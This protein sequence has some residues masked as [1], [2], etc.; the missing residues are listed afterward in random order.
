MMIIEAKNISY[1]YKNVLPYVIALKRINLYVNEGEM[2]AIQGPSGS[3][4]STLLHILGCM[5]PCQC[6]ELYIEGL[7]VSKLTNEQLSFLRNQK[8]GFIFQNPYLLP[9]SNILENILLPTNYPCEMRSHSSEYQKIAIDYAEKLGI[10]HRLNHFPNKLSGG[11]R[12]RVAIARGLIRGAKI[13]LADEPTGDLDSKRSQQ[14]IEYLKEMQRSE[15]LTVV[16]ITHNPEV[17]E[18][19]DRIVSIADGELTQT[20][21]PKRPW[22]KHKGSK[23]NKE[24]TRTEEFFASQKAMTTVCRGFFHLIPLAYKDIL[25]NKTRSLLTMVGIVIGI[26]ALLITVTL[27]QFTKGK[28]LASFNKLGSNALAIYSY[29]NWDQFDAESTPLL[30]NGFSIKNDILVLPKIFPKIVAISPVMSI[31][32]NQVRALYG[33]KTTSSGLALF[34]INKDFPA[35]IERKILLGENFADFDIAE[36]A[37]VCLIGS[38]IK[39]ILFKNQNPIGEKIQIEIAKNYYPCYVHGVLDKVEA[40]SFEGI[41][42]NLQLLIPYTFFEQIS[43]NRTYDKSWRF[44]AKID[45]ASNVLNVGRSIEVFFNLKYNRSGRFVIDPNI[46][47]LAQLQR[48]LNLFAIL[49]TAVSIITLIVGGIGITNMMLASIHDQYK[50]IGLRKAVGAT[51]NN[52]QA[53]FLVESI[54]ICSIAGLVGIILGI[55]IYETLIYTTSKIVTEFPFEFVFSKPAIY[56]SIVSMFLVGIISGI[57]PALKAKSLDIVTAMR[58]E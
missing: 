23:R 19:A 53:Q 45:S 27:G 56:L 44:L 41:D 25:R 6:G 34:G 35:I 32:G 57:N 58:S 17:A 50:E 31:W 22:L 13:L 26:A 46:T 5:L 43:P 33:G 1:I 15:N 29:P 11:E 36:S 8:M 24:K 28:I 42:Q 2:L 37:P 7:D 47:L 14:V 18:V 49:L 10:A 51:D 40:K 39:D 55:F 12:Q 21:L 30:F 20:S 16:I 54:I 4:K 48:F 9:R 38:A 3:G 52:M